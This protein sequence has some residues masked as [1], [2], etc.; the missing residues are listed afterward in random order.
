MSWIFLALGSHVFWAGENI[1][2]KYSVDKKIKNPYVFLI[3]FTLLEGVIF[4]IWPFINF[5]L[6]PL[7]VIGLLV[8]AGF[9]YFFGGFPYIKA[10]QSEEVTRVNILWGL[11]PVISLFFGYFFGERISGQESLALL[12]LVFG[13]ILASI[14]LGT[15]KWRFSRAFWLM[16]VAC[17]AFSAYGVVMHQV[18]KTTPF[19]NAFILILFFDF[20]YSL[21]VLFFS[22]KWLKEF[23]ETVGLIDWKF[24]LVLFLTVFTALG[25]GILNQL[26]LSLQQASLVFALEG[27]QII[28]VFV[29]TVLLTVFLPKI[30][31][32]KFDKKNLLFKLL[33]LVF[34]VVGI[35]ILNV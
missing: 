3:L 23:K 27:F 22:K 13:T 19:L 30:L 15:G 10:M 12:I 21:I 29:I 8:L 34:I 17:T 24:G 28:F 9:L 1:L 25:G 31:Q 35:V 33:A 26:A 14:H 11:I 20:L 5:T 32:E 2:T 18:F 7:P 16:L 6:P 4:I